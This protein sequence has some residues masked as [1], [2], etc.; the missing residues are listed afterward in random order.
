MR[1]LVVVGAS[2]AGLGAVEAARTSGFEGE[3]TFVGAERNLPYDR[4]PL[5]TAFLDVDGYGS[6]PPL[7]DE[8]QRRNELVVTMRLGTPATGL[9]TVA[10]VVGL[11]GA[12]VPYDALVIATGAHAGELPQGQHL[13]GVH[14]LRTV[15]DATA[16]RAAL[17][18]GAG[19]VVIGA[20][21]P[22]TP[23]S[24]RRPDAPAPHRGPTTETPSSPPPAQQD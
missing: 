22:A 11:D 6:R 19:T 16:I 18:D 10:R 14:A 23:T 8:A 5:S 9:D 17:D 3:V 15:N 21:S 13:A 12:S 2:L 20:G 1:R 4:P 7:R 24:Q